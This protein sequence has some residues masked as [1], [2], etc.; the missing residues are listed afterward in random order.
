M[1]LLLR[2]HHYPGRLIAIEGMD[3]CGKT[4]IENYVAEHYRNRGVEMLQT[5]QP[6]DW[7]RQ[8]PNVLAT[9]H[10]TGKGEQICDEAVALLGLADR[11][12]HQRMFLEPALAHDGIILCNRYVFSLFSHYMAFGGVELDWLR[13]AAS[14]VIRPDATILLMARTE[15]AIR[16]VVARDGRNRDAY[17]QRAPVVE[18]IMASFELL[19]EANDI[20]QV[21]TECEVSET[22]AKCI[23]IIDRIL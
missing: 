1:Q 9:V 20:D 14:F 17:D 12:N 11:A 22:A 8:D 16:R 3:G 23:A 2:K 13:T 19:A 5:Y 10:K 21:S 6:T 18:R 7:W 4:T 15:T